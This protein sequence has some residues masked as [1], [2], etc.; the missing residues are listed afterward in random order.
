LSKITLHAKDQPAGFP[1][2]YLVRPPASQR[3][4][5]QINAPSPHKVHT[6]PNGTPRRPTGKDH[7]R[8]ATG[9]LVVVADGTSALICRNT[10]PEAI[11]L[12]LPDTLTPHSL[13]NDGPAGS[14]PV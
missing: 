8:L 5:I 9:T 3:N 6:S 7:P 2:Y 4:L 14:T 1:H 12:D 10:G 11:K 13:Q